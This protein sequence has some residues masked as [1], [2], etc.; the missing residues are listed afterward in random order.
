[1]PVKP[2]LFIGSSQEGVE[3]ARAIHENLD[4]DAECSVWNQG[5]FE[6]NDNTLQRLVEKVSTSDFG[7]FVCSDDD[8]TEMRKKTSAAVRDNVVFELGMFLAGLG[9]G[10]AF[11]VVPENASDLHLPTDLTGITYGTYSTARR[12]SAWQQ[13][14]APFCN[15]VRRKIT[16]LGLAWKLE[17]EQLDKIAV[18]YACCEWIPDENPYGGT[19]RWQQKNE[20][21][22]RMVQTCQDTPPNKRLLYNRDVDVLPDAGLNYI[23]S[24]IR[25]FAASAANPEASDVD[26]ITSVP[27]TNLPDGNARIRALYAARNVAN[28][29][30]PSQPI[31]DQLRRWSE[32]AQ[33]QEHYVRDAQQLLYDALKRHAA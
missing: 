25:I 23:A 26:R 1:M 27:L 29:I 9:L 13:A 3:I 4:G 15:K 7:V 30:P 14:T 5:L 8:V 18:A 24:K 28:A 19:P 22:G 12:D 20:L 32:A 21:F 11:F 16:E 33:T 17:H 31:A 10:R 6:L 2:R